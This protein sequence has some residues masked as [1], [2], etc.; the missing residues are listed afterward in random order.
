MSINSLFDPFLSLEIMRNENTYFSKS[1]AQHFSNMKLFFF[2]SFLNLD[3]ST[4][5]NLEELSLV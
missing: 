1:L 5:M 3:N 2:F 4:S